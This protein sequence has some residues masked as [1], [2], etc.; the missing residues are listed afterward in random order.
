M[1]KI[2]IDC[3]TTGTD[4]KRHG[5]IQLAG[6]IEVP[7]KPPVEFNYSIK[8]FPN[9]IIDMAA[10]K[11]NGLTNYEIHEF[12][13]CSPRE[14]FTEFK[15]LLKKFVDPFDKRDKFVFIAYNARFDMDFLRTWW[16]MNNDN[17][18]GSWF[19]FPPRC[20]MH[21]AEFFL[22]KKRHLM[23]NFKLGTVAKELGINVDESKQHD[24][25]YDVE[26]AK[27]IEEKM[28]EMSHGTV[29]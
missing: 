25:M 10:L 22:E 2:Y 24:A 27:Q 8:P 7:N 12:P 9:D 5:L 14:I 23:P 16:M 4:P 29:N 17:Y 1:K 15:I 21:I 19:W 13:F 28:E 18:L 3:E 20:I 6:I 26:L 11:V